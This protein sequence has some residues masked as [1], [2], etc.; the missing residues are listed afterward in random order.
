MI[1]WFS[2]D[3]KTYRSTIEPSYA[4]YKCGAA[5][6]YDA[7]ASMNRVLHNLELRGAFLEGSADGGIGG[8]GELVIPYG[9]VG[10]PVRLNLYV[11]G[12]YQKELFFPV[13]GQKKL[14]ETPHQL[15]ISVMVNPGVNMIKV[16]SENGFQQ[17][18]LAIDHIVLETEKSHCKAY[19][20]ANG[21][22][23]PKGNGCW[24]HLPQ[25]ECDTSAFSGRAVKYLGTP[26]DSVKIISVDGGKGG[27]HIL[28]IR[29]SRAEDGESLYELEINGSVQTQLKFSRT[30][31][32]NMRQ[33]GKVTAEIS[34]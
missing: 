22:V 5:L 20:A 11:N 30:G 4:E 23:E 3:N 13:T 16:V 9:C 8:K 14:D 25:R 2:F 21:I 1:D 15:R 28:E 26:G 32:W 19:A 6:D 18:A 24:N 7:L 12:V 34:L 29:Y 31:S 17:G 27:G 10:E 33:F